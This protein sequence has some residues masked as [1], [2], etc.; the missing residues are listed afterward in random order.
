LILE[1]N[2]ESDEPAQINEGPE[3]QELTK[4][5]EPSREDMPAT[6][7]E[8]AQGEDP[9][10]PTKPA[11]ASKRKKKDKKKVSAGK[12]KKK[13]ATVAPA[14]AV[15][16]RDFVAEPTTVEDP[17]AL[18]EDVIQETPAEELLPSSE[19]IEVLDEIDAAAASVEAPTDDKDTS[20]PVEESVETAPEESPA[21]GVPADEADGISPVPEPANVLEIVKDMQ[22]A[23]ASD[24]EIN[25]VLEKAL[26]EVDR[27]GEAEIQ[28]EIEIAGD[29]DEAAAD[30]A[31]A[32]EP[33][34][35][36]PGSF[37]ES[38]SQEDSASPAEPEATSAT[39][40]KATPDEPE[41]VGLEEVP[42]ASEGNDG[43]LAAEDKVSDLAEPISL[44]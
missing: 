20:E 32:D 37:P 22:D 5:G 23:D 36:I 25:E 15:E 17:A 42:I 33:Q 38:D 18:P 44:E 28:G 21:S 9:V 2:A 24:K 12:T 43:E 39:E 27:C 26:S 34:K 31:D 7:D 30:G 35:D 6:Q 14:A 10:V 40:E 3:A 11:E 29:G 16:V 19:A 41:A 1:P 4:E 13:V 8:P